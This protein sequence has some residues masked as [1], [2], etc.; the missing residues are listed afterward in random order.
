MNGAIR[1]AILTVSDRCSRGE[2]QDTSGPA[3]RQILEQRLSATVLRTALVPDEPDIIAAHFREWAAS[4]DQLDLI[5][6]TGGTGLNPRDRTP[7]AAKQVC[8]REAPGI[9]ELA[10]ARCIA[11]DPRAA[12]SRATAGTIRSTLLLTLPGSRKGSTEYLEALLDVL[13]HAIHI[14]RGGGH[15]QRQSTIPTDNH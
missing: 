6:A 12:L 13:P 7:E 14:L 2:A 15:E 8:D 4:D 11:K 3:L 10:R 9:M 5:L 1:A